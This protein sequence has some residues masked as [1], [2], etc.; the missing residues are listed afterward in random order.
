MVSAP[1]FSIR[2]SESFRSGEVLLYG[3]WENA[4]GISPS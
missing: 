3:F 4:A 1:K 2:C